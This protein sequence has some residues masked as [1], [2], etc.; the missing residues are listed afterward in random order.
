MRYTTKHLSEVFD[1]QFLDAV[2]FNTDA[3]E[4]TAKEMKL[5]FDRIEKYEDKNNCQFVTMIHEL[6]VFRNNG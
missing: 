4:I 5:F 2:L 1:P 6:I 3:G